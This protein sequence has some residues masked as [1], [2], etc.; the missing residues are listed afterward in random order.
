MTPK[1]QIR[2]IATALLRATA[3]MAP[4]QATE[5]AH[6]MIAE[7]HHIEGDWSAL[8]WSVGSAGVLAKNAFIAF[9]LPGNTNQ[10]APS[11][12]FFAKEKPMRKSTAI[13]AGVCIA[14][15]LL[16]FAVPAFREAFSISLKQW[17]A[18][19]AYE[20]QF[21]YSDPIMEALADRARQNHD[22]EGLAFAAIHEHDEGRSAQFAEEAV[23]MDPRL[24]WVYASV[25]VQHPTAPGVTTWVSNLESFDPQNALSRFILVEKIDIEGVVSGK[26]L[27]V[28][29]SETPV[30]QNAMAA[31][32][33][34][35]RLDDYSEQVNAIDRAV[36]QRYKLEDPEV[37][38]EARWTWLPTYAVGNT[39]E[40][41]NTL[42]AS[43]DDLE[44]HGDEQGARQKYLLVANFVPQMKLSPN[45]SGFVARPLETAY[46]RLASLSREQGDA[47]QARMYVQ[48]A[49]QVEQ[50]QAQW[51]ATIQQHIEGDPETRWKA[52][53]VEFCGMLMPACAIALLAS[54]A[55]ALVRARSLR[56]SEFS[57]RR[58][59]LS[60]GFL[61]AAGLLASS[62]ALYLVYRPYSQIY[63]TYLLTGDS[64]HMSEFTDFLSRAETP[65]DVPIIRPS[66]SVHFW[67]GILV[68]CAVALAF[69]TT[70][71]LW[72]KRP[73][74]PV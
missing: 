21:R 64:A 12:G 50:N 24:T 30:W 25:A 35:S 8:A 18:L 45:R 65:L 69:V 28:K 37:A 13:A 43:G 61:S 19:R 39:A 47:S 38:D 62:S 48:L 33:A 31:V 71:F 17:N 42:I 14:A 4:P 67:S 7:L 11:G 73:A 15:S 36:V 52:R 41:A 26:F 74:I 9:F 27:A 5:W 70:R 63:N 10:I 2:A 55:G 34:S 44:A 3:K 49:T 51:H 56:W 60:I 22:A 59:S 54:L 53:V 68:L 6:A 58:F 66:F 46:Q 23:Q 57:A 20:T 72:R 32:F 29:D 16:F 1:F 40:Y